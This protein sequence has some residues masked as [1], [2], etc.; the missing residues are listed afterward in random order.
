MVTY[1]CIEFSVESILRNY[2]EETKIDLD[3]SQREKVH[4]HFIGDTFSG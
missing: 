4:S 3:Y 2:T 1:H